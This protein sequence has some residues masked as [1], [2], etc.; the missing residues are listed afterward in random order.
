MEI[1]GK[2]IDEKTDKLCGVFVN[3]LICEDDEPTSIKVPL[4]M[5]KAIELEADGYN[6]IEVLDVPVYKIFDLGSC[7]VHADKNR[8]FFPDLEF[9]PMERMDNGEFAVYGYV[10]KRQEKIPYDSECL[11]KKIM[12]CE[13]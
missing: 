4:T 3:G 9:L 8:T 5:E 11:I 13:E 10:Y 12:G 6:Y 2:L 1:I 7:F